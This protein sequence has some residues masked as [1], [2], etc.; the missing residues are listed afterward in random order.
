MTYYSDSPAAVPFRRLQWKLTLSYAAVTFGTLIIAVIVAAILI[1]RTIFVPDNVMGAE[2]WTSITQEQV[3]SVMRP[4]LSQ[5][6]VDPSIV[7]AVLND[8]NATVSNRDLFR[9]GDTQFSVRTVGQVDIMVVGSD[10]TLLGASSRRLLPE[11]A[12]GQPLDPG[13][14]SGLGAPLEAALAGETDPERL[15]F[16]IDPGNE[17]L[18]VM[19]VFGAGEAARTALGAVV[20]HFESLPTQRD[21]PAHIFNVVGRSA[22][23]FVIGAAI[24][25]TA[26]GALTAGGII[27]RLSRLSAATYSWSQGNFTTLVDDHSGDE[28]SVL[29]DRMNIMAIQLQDLVDRRQEMAVTG[30]RNRLARELHDSAKQQAFAASAQLGAALALYERDPETARAHILEAEQLI[31]QV[32]NELNDL[33]LELRPAELTAGDLPAALEEYAANWAHQNDIEADLQVEG[34]GSLMPESERTLFRITQEAL[35]NTARHSQASRAEIRLRYERECVILMI[36]D[37]GAGFDPERPST[38]LG[39]RSMRERAQLLGG[40]IAI[41]SAPGQGTLIVVTCPAGA[42]AGDHQSINHV[43]LVH[44]V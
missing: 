18:F 26:F 41:K 5:E 19:P 36:G 30:E 43:H 9:L 31:D 17:F 32:R 22:V 29:A 21:I 14:L 23:V 10:G 38:G 35:A 39:L 6:P 42:P 16:E 2:E 40:T 1:F 24:L 3:V 13:Q 25:A 44:P 33:L 4:I 15:F 12:I 20:V 37:N 7:A 34:Q 8:V 11:E 27:K 28:L